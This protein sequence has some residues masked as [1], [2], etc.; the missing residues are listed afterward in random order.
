MKNVP[1][2]ASLAAVLLLLGA[3]AVRAD[4][5]PEAEAR[6]VVERTAMLRRVDR[7]FD[8]LDEVAH[9]LDRLKSDANARTRLD[10]TLRDVRTTIRGVRRELEKAPLAGAPSAARPGPAR[11]TG[12]TPPAPAAPPAAM[13]KDEFAAFKKAVEK[14]TF[15]DDKAQ[16]V[17]ETVRHGWF[18]SEQAAELVKAVGSQSDAQ[19]AAAVA[20]Y[21]RVVDK[22]NFHRVYDVLT[23]KTS[24]DEIRKKLGL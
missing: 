19:V 12:D 20:L 13:A 7:V 23:F 10:E 8:D 6:V 3:L 22:V 15:S 9:L 18:T 4:D 11:R 16:L 5:G 14:E 2:I 21:P 17:V 24:K 1:I